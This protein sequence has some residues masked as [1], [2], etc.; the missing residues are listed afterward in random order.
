MQL[1]IIYRLPPAA[2]ARASNPQ[3]FLCDMSVIA[4]LS[5]PSEPCGL[6]R[7]L[8]QSYYLHRWQQLPACL[9]QANRTTAGA[10]PLFLC[11]APWLLPQGM[12]W[13]DGWDN[14]GVLMHQQ[15]G[16]T[17]CKTKV[18][19]DQSLNA[20]IKMRQIVVLQGFFII[21]LH[22]ISSAFSYNNLPKYDTKY[23]PLII[24]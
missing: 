2:Q 10:H 7:L 6:G 24:K 11:W 16:T 17:P 4:V 5:C 22:I 3:Y 1:E 8:A 15:A 20:F 23:V 14:T 9:F 18:L 21:P 19:S 12:A 13:V